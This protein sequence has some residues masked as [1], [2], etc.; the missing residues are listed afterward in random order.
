MSSSDQPQYCF[1]PVAVLRSVFKE[2]F[3][4]P[5]QS[6]LAPHAT[7]TVELLPPFDQPDYIVGIDGC[8]HLWLQ[9]VFHLHSDTTPRAKVRPPRLGGNKRVGVFATRAPVRPNPI[10]LSVVQLLSVER[11]SGGCKLHVAGVDLVDGTPILDIKPYVPYA[12]SISTAC[13]EL[14]GQPPATLEVVFN[15]AVNELL[16]QVEAGY[17][18]L[19]L[20]ALAQDPRP[21]YTVPDP[22]RIFGALIGE[23]NVRWRYQRV[24][25]G[26][27]ERWQIEVIELE[28]AAG[29]H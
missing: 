7:A 8:S 6:G 21:Q 25:E 2:K 5:R 11:S 27:E 9:F 14:A 19:L 16:G 1:T 22:D 13:N 10:G 20:E 17:R 18:S 3:A 12:D 28:P 24:A 29:Q 4:V 23:Y 15:S 26:L